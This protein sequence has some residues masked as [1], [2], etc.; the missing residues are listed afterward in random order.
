MNSIYL[1]VISETIELFQC[2]HRNISDRSRLASFQFHFISPKLFYFI[3]LMLFTLVS[4]SF[5]LKPVFFAPGMTVSPL[6]ATIISS[7]KFPECEGF[8]LNHTKLWPVKK[9]MNECVSA[10]VDT[11]YHP[12]NDTFSHPD[13]VLIETDPISKANPGQF[14]KWHN[15]TWTVFYDW[16]LYYLGIQNTFEELK[17]SIEKAGFFFL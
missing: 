2:F 3:F 11:V 7:E 15:N 16:T 10:I 1:E 12:E 13:G 9:E 8:E 6:Y 17:N 14:L 4:L 5:C